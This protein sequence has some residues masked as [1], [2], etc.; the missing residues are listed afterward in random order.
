MLVTIGASRVN[1]ADSR[2]EVFYSAVK[3]LRLALSER[4]IKKLKRLLSEKVKFI[5]IIML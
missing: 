2:G 5:I 1:I 3:H 4:C